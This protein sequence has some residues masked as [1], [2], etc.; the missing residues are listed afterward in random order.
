MSLWSR[1]L[2]ITRLLERL[3]SPLVLNTGSL[4]YF[5]SQPQERNIIHHRFSLI[6]WLPPCFSVSSKHGFISHSPLTVRCTY[7][8]LK[9]P[10]HI[11][12]EYGNCN[13][14]RNSEQSSLFYVACS[15]KPK[16]MHTL[17]VCWL[18]IFWGIAE[19]SWHSFTRQDTE[20]QK[21]FGK[22]RS[23]VL[24]IVTQETS[25]NQLPRFYS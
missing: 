21:L 11:N 8:L 14:C 16:V 17:R 23:S 5:S 15:P 9:P 2:L 24:Q 18:R 22:V 1:P 12:L 13:I 6:T 3:L 25:D 19:V 20:T 10:E 4:K 7:G